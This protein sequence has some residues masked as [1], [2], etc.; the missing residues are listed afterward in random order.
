MELSWSTFA[1]E[2]INF[3]VLVWI[4]KRFLYR[5]VMEVIDRRR[6]SIESQL[7][8]AKQQQQAGNARKTEYENRLKKWDRERQQLRAELQQDLDSERNRQMEALQHNLEEI[9]KKA[10]VAQTQQQ[11]TMTRKLEHQ[12]LL[13]GSRFASRLLA[14]TAGTELEAQLLNLALEG[15]SKLSEDQ[16]KALQTQWGKQ[17]DRIDV[18]SAHPLSANQQQRLEQAMTNLVGNTIPI[19]YRQD[20]SLMAGIQL[21]VGSWTLAANLRDEL[22]GFA[23]FSHVN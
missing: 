16:T 7:S 18:T 4:L 13:Q 17:P 22:K 8:E 21:S 12:A 20:P 3:I 14:L 5:P 2:I 1:L 10:E 23:E 19:T 6:Q 9:R 15:L 11:A